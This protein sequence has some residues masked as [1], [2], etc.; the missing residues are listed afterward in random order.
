MQF[1]SDISDCTMRRPVIRATTAL[2][3]VAYLAGLATGVWHSR[4]ELKQLSAVRY[5]V[6]ALDGRE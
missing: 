3:R 1:Q 5:A 2:W 6:C 4:E